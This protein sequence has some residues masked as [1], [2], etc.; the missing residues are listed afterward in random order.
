MSQQ[1]LGAEGLDANGAAQG[2]VPAVPPA[3]VVSKGKNKTYRGVRQRPWGKWAAEIRDPTVGARRWLGTFDTAEEAARAYD[4]AARAIR[5]PAARCNFPLPEEMSA[6]QVEAHCKAEKERLIKSDAEKGKVH[7]GAVMGAAAAAHHQQYQ[8]YVHPAAMHGGAVVSAAALVTDGNKVRGVKAGPRKVKKQA[9]GMMPCGVPGP[10]GPS[11]AVAAVLEGNGILMGSSVDEHHLIHKPAKM[12]LAASDIT[13]AMAVADAMHFGGG[14]NGASPSLLFAGLHH[15]APGSGTHGKLPEWPPAGSLGG[16]LGMGMGLSP[17]HMMMFGTP[18]LG[19]SVDMVDVCT[20]L[21]EAGVDHM[22]MG[23]LRAEL[24]LPPCMALG[25]DEDEDEHEAEMA[26]LG[27]G[28]GSFSKPGGPGSMPPPPP[29][30]R[31][32]SNSGAASEDSASEDDDMMGMSPELPSGLLMAAAAAGRPTG[33]APGT[34]F[35]P[36]VF[37]QA[38][39][40]HAQGASVVAAGGAAVTGWAPSAPV[41]NLGR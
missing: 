32:V 26:I 20:Q 37:Q 12:G 25:E 22:A 40:M 15:G 28:T 7:A 18:P 14:V 38:F 10:A 34:G 11:A 17:G 5:G 1:M 4:A 24:L 19:R 33:I 29:R 30:Q 3:M 36:N 35:P 9:F 21:M 27:Q 39:R 41:S 13:G 2:L 31:Q 23:S 8:Q 16:S 6:Q